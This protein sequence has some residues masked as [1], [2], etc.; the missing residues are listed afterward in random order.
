MCR[1]LAALFAQALILT[2]AANSFAAP[3]A[4]NPNP[5][6]TATGC[7]PS[8]TITWTAGD[9][10]AD[11]VP[12][13]NTNGHHVFLHTN[14]SWVDG[15]NLNYPLGT[16]VGHYRAETASFSPTD[17]CSGIGS[18][19]A[20]ETTYYW[21]IIEVNDTNPQSPWVG[22]VWSFSTIGTQAAGPKPSNG[23]EG[24]PINPTLTWRPGTRV[25]YS[26]DG[27]HDIYFGTDQSAVADANT[28][29]PLGVYIVR[30][31]ANQF[32]PGQL[33]LQ[34]TYYWRIDEANDTSGIITGR[35]WS[36]TTTGLSAAAP[37]PADNATVA[38]LY[39]GTVDVT[40]SWKRGAYAANTN[41]HD[42]YF[43]TNEYLVSS[44]TSTGPNPFGIYKGRQTATT[45]PLNGLQL[46]VKYYWRI[47]EVND[48]H[49]DVLWKGPLWQ[50]TTS[51]GKASNPQ[52]AD[53]EQRAPIKVELSWTAGPA[54]TLHDVYFG[55]SS[56]P[57]FI[58]SGSSTTYNPGILSRD[59][60][61]YW[62][63]DEHNTA[64]TKQGDLWSFKTSAVNH[65]VVTIDQSTTYQTI[66]GFGAHG[67]MNVWWSSGPF[68]N[69]NFLDLV[70]DDLGLTINRNEYYP[71]PDAPGQWPKQTPY[72]QALKAKADA[73]GE[74]LKFIAAYW[75]P[76]S[77]M[78]S[79]GS[80]TNGGYLLPQYY[81]DFGDYSVQA[82]QDYNDIGIDLYA[83]SM[84]NEPNFVEPYNSC[85]YSH[86]QY[87]DMLKV[88]GPIIHTAFPDVKL[89]G[90][91]HM[92]WPQQWDGTAYEYDIIN[93]PAANAQMGIWAVHG[94]G[95][96]GQ[97]PDPGSAEAAAWT[98]GKN[99]FEPTGKNFWM[100]ETSGYHENWTDS[101]QL[102]QS[103]YAALKYG[104][105]S[106]WVWW[107]LSEN[108]MSEFVLMNLG[109]PS[110][111]YYI[112][113]H[114]YR[115]IRPEAV[116]VESDSDNQNL[117][118]VAFKHPGHNTSTI[119]L[120]NAAASAKTVELHIAG[121][122]LPHKYD[123]YITTDSEDCLYAGTTAHN[124]SVVMPASSVATL[125]GTDLC[126]QCDISSDGSVNFADFAYLA[127]QW[128]GPPAS[129]S[130]DVAPAGGDGS[131]DIE[132]L[133]AIA[134]CWMK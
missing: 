78:K 98:Y 57:P 50:F 55:T 58:T 84:Q 60:T 112:S 129:P 16:T 63:I 20:V 41:G 8:L 40:L 19:L 114:Y 42:V 46:D 68:Y 48:S 124:G 43:G 1:K 25:A 69:D 122:I 71:K 83:L 53:T 91:E 31:D 88:T 103:I 24:V 30:K 6:D 94:Y 49:P 36:F 93:T 28:T 126:P 11:Y 10:V 110:K 22:L 21:R 100:T 70:I 18:P 9:Y 44:T 90:V 107:Q 117:M 56:P 105:I 23:E 14:F 115:Y 80:T 62:R 87:V 77:W 132:D 5:E 119:V 33:L 54:A 92:L 66:D 51:S 111:R 130:A 116:M 121:D 102:A 133:E 65:P 59:T 109:T 81:D 99:R 26:P 15:A 34:T 134:N 120:I 76:P 73:S 52:P 39:N 12:G 64:G 79:N 96:D 4:G 118:V 123:V 35:L 108:G 101:M 13:K 38:E 86:Q 85:V 113:K 3:V 106:A 29:N 82:I 72:L 2:L 97:T 74:P 17:P 89:Y 7:S 45:Y 37:A 104:H 127:D 131:V 125:Y 27:G 95:N 128:L 61:Y 47:D 67:A 75:S 32:S